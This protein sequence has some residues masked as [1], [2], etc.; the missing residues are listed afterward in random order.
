LRQFEAES[1]GQN[2][3]ISLLELQNKQKPEEI[4]LLR[5][6]ELLKNRNEI[7]EL[8]GKLI[9]QEKN[10]LEDAKITNSKRAARLMPLSLLT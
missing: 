5:P 1:V 10:V 8:N 9:N 3:R 6:D 7:K 2:N 4:N